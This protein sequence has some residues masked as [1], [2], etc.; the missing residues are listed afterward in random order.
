MVRDTYLKFFDGRP[1]AR[2]KLLK[3][4]HQPLKTAIPVSQQQDHTHQ[5]ADAQKFTG[6]REKLQ[7]KKIVVV[8]YELR[9]H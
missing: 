9:L 2:R 3:N 4:G 8:D 5:V 1:T 7:Q 6:D